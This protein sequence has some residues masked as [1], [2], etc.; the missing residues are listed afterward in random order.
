[1]NALSLDQQREEFAAR[2]F[3]AMPIAGMIAWALI[4]VAGATL[5]LNGQVWA[6]YIGTGFIFYL[7]LLVA[8]FT[9]EDLL[10]RHRPK[11][12]FDRLFMNGVAGALLVYALAIPFFLEEPTS[13]PLTVGVLA[14]L[15]WM[16]FSWIIQHW[17]GI[18]HAVTRTV[19]CVAAYY[20]FPEAR[21]VAIP[22]VIV[23]IYAITILV[24]L[25]RRREVSLVATAAT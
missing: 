15:M 19:L 11:N 25:R 4:A 6:V 23:A 21:F 3:L 16:P 17:V 20:A 2:P 7:G 22:A 1:M 12:V 14:G 10:G 13:L 9:G 8:K 5:S 24:L 18:F